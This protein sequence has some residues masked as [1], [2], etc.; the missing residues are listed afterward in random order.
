MDL[1]LSEEQ[2]MIQDMTAALL[3]EHSSKEIVRSMENDP[4]GYP[5]ALWKHMAESGLTGVLI[6]ESHGGGGQTLLEA[7]LIYEEIGRAMAPTPH[8]VSAVLSAG[9]LLEAGSAGN[10]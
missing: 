1:E 10:T 6:P 8:F 9:M 4:K 2:Q 3:E 5:D 7:A